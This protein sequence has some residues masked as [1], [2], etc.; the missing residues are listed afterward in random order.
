MKQQEYNVY[1]I[2]FPNFSPDQYLGSPG[3]FPL[4]MFFCLI[5]S[6]LLLHQQSSGQALDQSSKIEEAHHV[7]V[8][9]FTSS[10]CNRCPK[11]E[12]YFGKLRQKSYSTRLVQ[13]AWH[14]DYYND[15]G[16]PDPFSQSQFTNRQRRYTRKRGVPLDV[17]VFLVN[18]KLVKTSPEKLIEQALREEKSMHIHAKPT[19]N[20][21]SVSL[22]ISIELLGKLPY[23]LKRVMVVPVLYQK[24][25]TTVP[26]S[27][28]N[29]NTSISHHFVVKR[30][31]PPLYLEET[32]KRAGGGH[33][34]SF[35]LPEDTSPEQL[36]VAILVEHRKEMNTLEASTIPLK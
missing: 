27:G 8:E 36:G 18:N 33:K 16:E 11:A 32:L 9:L 7:L 14:V 1:Q 28:P 21:T 10:N 3:Y 15:V 34:I 30:I 4:S 17:P 6:S 5:L 20:N 29:Q 26:E 25:Q 22:L 31:H 12:K 23:D 13:L 2:L 35:Q 19:L 24:Q